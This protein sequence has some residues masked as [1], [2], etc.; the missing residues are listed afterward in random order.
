MYCQEDY[1]PKS[2]LSFYLLQAVKIVKSEKA[3]MCRLIAN[4]T[5]PHL[6]PLSPH[7][8]LIP[9]FSW[10]NFYYNTFQYSDNPFI[11]RSDFFHDYG[12]FLE[13]VSGPYGEN[14]YAIRIMKSRAKIAISKIYQFKENQESESVIM[15]K[16]AK[17][18]RLF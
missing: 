15:G 13:N 3:D 9:K 4:Y 7:F 18:K 12:F 1:I 6:I 16:G 17:N 10:R 14:E 5:F 11:T 2:E 8:S